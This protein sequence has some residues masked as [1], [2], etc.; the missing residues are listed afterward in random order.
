MTRKN[1]I[2]LIAVSI[3]IIS[4][5]CSVPGVA[6]VTPENT[7]ATLDAARTQAVETAI[8]DLTA[9]AILHPSATA[10]VPTA[11]A[12][13]PPTETPLPTMTFTASPTA[14][15]TLVPTRAR[16]NTPVNVLC[17]VVSSSPDTTTLIKPGVDFDGRWRVE[18]TGEDA[19]E[20]SEV[21]F[22]FVGGTK[23]HVHQDDYDLK[24]RVKPDEKI[25]LILDM[26]SPT[27]PGYYNTTWALVKG[28]QTICNLYLQIRVQ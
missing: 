5:A 3:L 18:N 14:T 13:T 9:Q 10:T 17:K 25:D 12:T 27:T 28:S 24:K 2:S 6:A 26:V 15:R 21:D 23:L 1:T 19:W 11:T 20:T 8:F 7:A 22:V 16:T 4:A